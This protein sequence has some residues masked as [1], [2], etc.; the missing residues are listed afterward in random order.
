MYRTFAGKSGR[1]DEWFGDIVP[2]GYNSKTKK[3]HIH[4]FESDAESEDLNIHEVL[5]SLHDTDN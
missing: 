2:S 1:V 5:A 3:W 4:Y